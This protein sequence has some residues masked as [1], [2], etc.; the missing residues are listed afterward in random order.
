M[1][2]LAVIIPWRESGDPDRTAAFTYTLRYYLHLRIGQVIPI[3]DARQ[4][5]QPFNRH[6]A[7]NRGL[8]LTDAPVI[9]WNE[10]DTLIP[11]GQIEQAARLALDHPGLVI[12]YTERHELDAHQ[13]GRVYDGIDPFT[14][15]GATIYPD[16][17]SIGQAGVTSRATLDAVGGHWPEM[18]HGWGYDDN[19]AFHAFTTLAGPTRW[20]AGKGVHLWHLPAFKVHDPQRVQTTERNR[21]HYQRM[22]AMTPDRLRDYLAS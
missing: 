10:A 18:F 13:A 20:V 8:A 16:G 14:L 4:P 2:D 11:P 12:P 21:V 22:R 15:D 7:Y 9:L 3:D 1:T 6:A 17:T 19:A 5:G